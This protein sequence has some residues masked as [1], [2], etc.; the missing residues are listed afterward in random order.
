MPSL[1]FPTEMSEVTSRA[2]L[3]LE[4]SAKD[5]RREM[6]TALRGFGLSGPAART[7]SALA[8]LPKATAAD[9]VQRTGIPDSKIYYALGELTEVG[10]AEVQE[11]KPKRYR[12]VGAREVEARLHRLLEARY[13]RERAAVRRVASL[14]EPLQAGARSPAMELA[15]VVKGR[16]NVLRRAEAMI[17][18]A[19][20]DLL[21]IASD[22]GFLRRLQT[23]LA[24][25]VRRG[26]RIRLAIPDV[27]LPEDLARRA[28]VRSVVCSGLVLV[29]DVQQILTVNAAPE[30][31][32]YGITSTDETLVRMGL[33]FWESPRCCV[34][35]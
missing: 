30:E 7:F 32:V 1:P 18:S 11:G 20:E 22:E 28:E 6:G 25:A 26:T 3:L 34:V 35:C 29:A 8:G 14:L 10:L 5:A 4:E 13:E 23:P 24:K 12:T 16:E 15:Y 9:L 19:R 17:R 27:P 2:N 33:A 21:L 31:E